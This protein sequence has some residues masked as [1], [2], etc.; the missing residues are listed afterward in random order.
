VY[1]PLDT[2]GPNPNNVEFDNLYLD[3]NGIIHPCVHPEGREA[4]ATEELMVE[5]IFEFIDHIFSIVRPRRLLFMAVDGVAPRAKMNQ[6]RSRRFKSVREASRDE[7]TNQLVQQAVEE[8]MRRRGREPPPRRVKERFDHNCITPGT[9]FM[10]K[11]CEGLRY[12]VSERLSRDPGWKGLQVIISDCTVPGEGEHKVMEFIRSQRFQEDYDPNT[13]H[14]IYGLDADLIMLSMA[15]HELRFSV[16]RERITKGGNR[17]NK[18]GKGGHMARDCNMETQ[19]V[20]RVDGAGV[21]SVVQQDYQ[22]LDIPT[23]KEYLVLEMK[24]E[25]D[26]TVRLGRRACHGRLC[27]DLLLCW[28]R[29]LASSTVARD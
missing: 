26:P 6:Q 24:P 13:R 9:T 28:K 2:S 16:L 23:L 20:Q 4:P 3:M 18:C 11:V 7:I 8:E 14:C 17:C 19:F 29:F 15:T 10:A 27:V 1:A 5:A 25:M 21:S 22:F 12:Y